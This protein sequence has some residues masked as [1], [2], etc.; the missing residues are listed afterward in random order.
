MKKLVLDIPDTVDVSEQEAKTLLASSLYE[1]GKLSLG[2]A[3]EL[4][5]YSKRTFIELLDSV[6]VSIFSDSE[7]ELEN[8]IANAKRYHI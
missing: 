4:A 8:D 3:S 1:S 2:Q 6:N 7:Q 5:G